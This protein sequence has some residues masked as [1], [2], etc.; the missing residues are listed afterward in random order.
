MT[1]R[2]LVRSMRV[3]VCPG[4]IVVCGCEVGCEVWSDL[5]KG[6]VVRC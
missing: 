2:G 5:S 6:V 1:Q 4:D 3:V